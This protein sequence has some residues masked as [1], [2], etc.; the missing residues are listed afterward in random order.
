MKHRF[1]ESV[2][3]QCSP[4]NFHK[5]HKKKLREWETSIV[6]PVIHTDILPQ[7][8]PQIVCPADQAVI[9]SDNSAIWYPVVGEWCSS[10]VQM[11]AWHRVEVAFHIHLLINTFFLS[12]SVHRL[13]H[14]VQAL[15]E[16]ANG[17]PQ[18]LSWRF[19]LPLFLSS[20]SSSSYPFY[21][22]PLTESKRWAQ[23][24]KVPLCPRR[25]PLHLTAIAVPPPNMTADR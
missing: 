20:S 3:A 18:L 13:E 12:S 7:H 5:F 25:S 10:P 22:L 23:R 2:C 14:C 9:L 21:V 1:I 6:C 15:E 8:N 19:P 16:Q 17:E 24:K 11:K 4:H